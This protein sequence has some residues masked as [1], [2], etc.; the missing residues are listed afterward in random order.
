MTA[1]HTPTYYR[2]RT[3]VRIAF[4]AG[5]A[6]TAFTIGKVLASE[7]Y[8]YK[9]DGTTVVVVGGD[10]LWSLAEQH[11]KGHTGHAVHRLVAT[12]GTDIHAGDTISFAIA[13]E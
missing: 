13:S 3:A 7:P 11:C 2:I 4:L 9:C 5:V 10:T 1:H 8:P 6:L 12:Y